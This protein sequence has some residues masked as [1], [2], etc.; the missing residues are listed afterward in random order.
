MTEGFIQLNKALAL[1][2]EQASRF[3]SFAAQFN[4]SIKFVRNESVTN[5]KSI[6]NVLSMDLHQ[7][8][9]IKVRV[10]GPDEKRTLSE[11]MQYMDKLG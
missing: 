3:V 5:A 2:A 9:R 1:Q 11:I 4:C 10:D 7:G 6:L 8:E